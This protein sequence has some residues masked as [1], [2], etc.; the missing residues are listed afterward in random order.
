MPEEFDPA[1]EYFTSDPELEDVISEKEI[2]PF[3]KLGFLD[4]ETERLSNVSA[5][6]RFGH[7]NPNRAFLKIRRTGKNPGHTVESKKLHTQEDYYYL[8]SCPGCGDRFKSLIK[9][10]PFC[11]PSC[12]DLYSKRMES[13]KKANQ[14]TK[15]I[16]RRRF[17]GRKRELPDRTC[18]TCGVVYRPARSIKVYCSRKCY[19]PKGRKKER[20]D[21]SRCEFCGVLFAPKRKSQSYCSSKCGSH[22]YALQRRL[23]QSVSVWIMTLDEAK[24]L[25]VRGA[26]IGDVLQFL[27]ES[28]HDQIKNW[29]VRTKDIPQEVFDARKASVAKDV[30]RVPSIRAI[31][32]KG[33]SRD[34][35]VS[36]EPCHKCGGQIFIPG[37]CPTCANCGESAK[38]CG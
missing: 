8:H 10:N 27:D 5:G 6:F 12:V 24:D 30:I 15:K 17:N 18:P 32:A 14:E 29:F 3:T 37:A 25:I 22:K 13:L 34:P 26:M 21:T 20:P 4:R 33:S 35:Q 28:L 38:G 23:L 31:P 11:T 16:G 1:W 36:H 19:K 9:N 2:H 7:G